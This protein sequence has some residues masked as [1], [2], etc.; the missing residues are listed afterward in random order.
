MSAFPR[1]IGS[2]VVDEMAFRRILINLVTNAI[3]YGGDPVNISDP[4]IPSR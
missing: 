2:I 3:K 1:S 4:G